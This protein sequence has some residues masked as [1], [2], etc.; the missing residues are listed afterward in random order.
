MMQRPLAQAFGVLKRGVLSQQTRSVV[1]GPP[2]QKVTSA[3]MVLCCSAIGISCM[4][5]PLYVIVHVPQYR[6]GSSES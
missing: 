6:G 1:S 4:A 5:I 3:Q 2:T